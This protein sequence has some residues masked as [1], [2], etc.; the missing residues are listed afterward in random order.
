M[1][2]YDDMFSISSRFESLS[3]EEPKS[4]STHSTDF[5]ESVIL[6]SPKSATLARR[7]PVCSG[8]KGDMSCRVRWHSS[9]L[10]Y[11]SAKY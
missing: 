8:A 5:K 11:L 10:C 3:F 6:D 7:A 4:F 1:E 2:S 9:D